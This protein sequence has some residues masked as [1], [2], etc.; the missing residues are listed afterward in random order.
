M[1]LDFSIS[2]QPQRYKLLIGLVMPRPIALVTSLGPTGIVN[3][4]P[5][6]FFNMFSEEPPLVVL[7][8]QIAPERRL[9]D[10]LRPYPRAGAFVVNLVDE[11]LAEQ[12]N[13]CAVDFPPERARSTPRAR[14]AARQIC[15]GAAHRQAPAA[16]E[17][18]H[19]MTLEV[20]ALAPP[21]HRP[22]H[23]V[24]TSATASWIRA[25]CASTSTIIGRW[26]ACTEIITPA[27]EKSFSS[28]ASL[29]PIGRPRL[30]SL[31]A[32]NHRDPRVL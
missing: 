18:R 5:F 7:G 29:I 12:M 17:C 22:G 27:W 6:S 9:K 21:R 15:A 30:R 32:D 26:R 11:A 13:I 23:L 14:P 19:Y 8:L 2:P 10:T 3:A 1:T 24:C 28:C 31:P 4:A 20:S 16:L 25:S